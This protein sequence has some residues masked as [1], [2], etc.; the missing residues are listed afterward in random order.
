MKWKPARPA[1]ARPNA[2][3]PKGPWPVL[4]VD[5]R[6]VRKKALASYERALR[7]LD[8]LKSDLD[9][10]ETQDRPA[11]RQWFHRLFGALLTEGR[12]LEAKLAELRFVAQQVSLRALMEHRG[13]VGRAY[14]EFVREREAEASRPPDAEPE[15]PPS[16]SRP[17]PGEQFWE[18]MA[19]EMG[20][21][22]GPGA[23][24]AFR[25]FA[26]DFGFDLGND[27]FGSLPPG[28][29]GGEAPAPVEASVKDLYRR[30]VRRLHP[31]SGRELSPK[32][33]EWWHEAQEAYERRDGRA[34]ELILTL[35]EIEDQGTKNARVS[36]LAELTARCRS[37]L[38]ELRRQ[39]KSSRSDP[40]WQF[41]EAADSSGIEKEMRRDLTQRNRGMSSEVRHLE[42]MIAEWKRQAEAQAASR[43]QPKSRPR[44]APRYADPLQ[45]EFF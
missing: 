32:E 16:G 38:R 8:K 5:S 40:A 23:E 9:R 45:R 4:C 28:A 2:P 27:P 29:L 26:R 13:N 24:E 1:A 19:D 18:E 42:A 39:L 3:R 44:R 7:E 14:Q 36:I 21:A 6:S 25:E 43:S 31:D 37:T 15:P 41:S 10:F 17:P 11:F 34:L 20:G 30:I 33:I 12:E 35:C 22:F